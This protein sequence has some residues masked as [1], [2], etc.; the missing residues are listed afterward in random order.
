MEEEGSALAMARISLEQMKVKVKDLKKHRDKEMHR[1]KAAEEMLRE[2]Q[3]EKYVQLLKCKLIEERLEKLAKRSKAE[4]KKCSNVGNQLQELR[5]DAKRAKK[6]KKKAEVQMER[7]KNQ[8]KLLL[9]GGS[10]EC[11]L[12]ELYDLEKALVRSKDLL[13]ERMI[14]MKVE[15]EFQRRSELESAT[16]GVRGVCVVCMDADRELLFVPCGHR[17]CCKRCSERLNTCPL[18]RSPIADRHLIYE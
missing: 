5:A 13:V 3:K 11:S 6:D 8:N 18:C 17:A 12:Q 15:E 1:R 4:A 14:K 2:F 7:V 9:E 10:D 16:N